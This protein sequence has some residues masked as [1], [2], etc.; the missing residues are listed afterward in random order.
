MKRLTRKE[1]LS[2]SFFLCFNI[3]CEDCYG[4]CHRLGEAST[5]NKDSSWDVEDWFFTECVQSKKYFQHQIEVNRQQ[6]DKIKWVFHLG[7]RMM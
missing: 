3:S 6:Y 4:A 1:Y 7:V 5:M 2:L